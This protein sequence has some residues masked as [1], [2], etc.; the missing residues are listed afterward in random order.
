MY[1]GSESYSMFKTGKDSNVYIYNEI[2][3]LVPCSEVIEAE[4]IIADLEL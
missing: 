1:L 3:V 4:K 2:K